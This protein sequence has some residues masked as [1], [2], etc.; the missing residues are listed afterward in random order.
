MNDWLPL[1]YA[2]L[3]PSVALWLIATSFIGSFI[4]VALGIGG[5]VL[6]LSI[7]ATLLP[8]AAL[9]PVHGVIQ[10]G[11]NFTRA[12]M[13]RR[14]IYWAP[15][16]IFAVGT[17]IGVAIGGLVVVD[18]PASFLQIGIGVFVIWS[19]LSKPPAWLSRNPILTGG[20]ASF[21]T[22]FFGATGIFVANFTKS[23]NLERHTH[24]ATHAVFMTLQHSLKIVTFAI[25]GFAFGPWI[26][27]I[28]AM[29]LAGVLGTF[30]GKFVLIRIPE[31]IFKRVFNVALVMIAL[32][33]IW[34]GIR[35]Y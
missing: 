19:V 15:V 14:H 22:M 26:F 10:L 2:G 31:K 33:L 35:S 18:L 4:S 34:S 32:R 8:A 25:L 11:S 3:E 9:V 30:F 6:L 5:G 28:A 12:V 20:I 24:V 7:M 13:L 17:A 21:L 23:L 29:I 27:F 1:I 16:L